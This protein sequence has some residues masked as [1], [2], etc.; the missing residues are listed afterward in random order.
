M[1]GLYPWFHDLNKIDRLPEAVVGLI[2]LLSSVFCGAFI[3]LERQRREK[4]AGLRTV[5]LITLGSTI[6]TL[7]SLMLARSK[8]IADPA[9]LASQ[10]VPGIGFLGAGAIIYA[11]GHLIGLTTGATIWACAAVGVTIGSGYVAAGVFFTVVIFLTLTVLQK[12][13]IL[14]GGRCE[15]A[16]FT[17]R[18]RPNCGKTWVRLQHVLDRFNLE[19][20]A[21]RH[22]SAS[23]EERTVEID[24]CTVHRSHR[25]ILKEIVD[26]DEVVGIECRPALCRT[27]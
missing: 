4:P 20:V 25:G 24:V 23:G 18:Y 22:V 3:G 21:V 14:L 7:V 19:D 5:I 27:A 11:R 10:I 2:C 8:P 17:V 1:D 26:D 16:T 6:F 9:R 13:E 12:V 15:H